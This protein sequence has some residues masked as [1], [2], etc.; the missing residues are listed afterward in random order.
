M[1]FLSPHSLSSSEL[2]AEPEYCTVCYS[3]ATVAS[4]LLSESENPGTTVLRI[5]YV[6]RRLIV[7]CVEVT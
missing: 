5:R 2:V 1:K 3:E 6:R 4:K 7:M